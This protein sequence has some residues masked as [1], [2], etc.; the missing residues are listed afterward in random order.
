MRSAF[1]APEPCGPAWCP[2][3]LAAG[4][5]VLLSVILGFIGSRRRNAG[6]G[7]FT[8][9]HSL[10]VEYTPTTTDALET[11]T[12]SQMHDE[13]AKA[14]EAVEEARALAVHFKCHAEQARTEQGRLNRL[15]NTLVVAGAANVKPA[16]KRAA[17]DAAAR[18]SAGAAASGKEGSPGSLRSAQFNVNGSSGGLPP[19]PTFRQFHATLWSVPNSSP[20]KAWRLATNARPQLSW[21]MSSEANSKIMAT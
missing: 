16:D 13:V 1:I 9:E 3:V 21:L 8:M 17:K 14:H 2:G 12:V 6:K 7:L 19:S 5:L 10:N 15:L 20:E 18:L 11:M 4:V